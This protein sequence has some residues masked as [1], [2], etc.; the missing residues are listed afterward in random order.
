MTKRTAQTLNL[1]D[2]ISDVPD[3]RGRDPYM[4]RI[5]WD[6]IPGCTRCGSTDWIH[7]LVA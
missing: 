5:R 3:R 4:E 2:L 1:F 7:L 6:E